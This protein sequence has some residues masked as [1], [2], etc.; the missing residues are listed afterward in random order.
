MC[1]PLCTLLHANRSLQVLKKHDKISGY[2]TREKFMANVMARQ[3]FAWCPNVHEML[4]RIEVIFKQIEVRVHL[5][6]S[7]CRYYKA[8]PLL[9]YVHLSVH[10]PTVLAHCCKHLQLRISYSETID[11]HCALL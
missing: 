3:P 8:L 4:E 1:L 6:L 11:L 9:S 5:S 7:H 10:T 2:A